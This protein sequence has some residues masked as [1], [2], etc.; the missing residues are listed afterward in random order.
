MKTHRK[1]FPLELMCRVFEV[2]KS[3][4][5]AT[6]PR[7]PALGL[8]QKFSEIVDDRFETARRKPTLGLLIDGF[9]GRQVMR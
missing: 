2:S 5:Y 3:G 6:G 1:D 9:P 7:F 4:Y 8:A